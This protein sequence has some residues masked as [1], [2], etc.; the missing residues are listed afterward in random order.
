MYKGGTKV[1]LWTLISI[2]WLID[3]MVFNANFSNISAISWRY[4]YFD[5][6][7]KIKVV[8]ICPATG[9]QRPFLIEYTAS[10]L[11]ASEILIYFMSTAELFICDSIKSMIRRKGIP[12]YTHIPNLFLNWTSIVLRHIINRYNYTNISFTTGHVLYL[13]CGL[14]LQFPVSDMS[15]FFFHTKM[16]PKQFEDVTGRKQRPYIEVKKRKTKN[17]TLSKHFRNQEKS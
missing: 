16:L 7:K 5:C 12:L 3:L 13:L 9:H 8:K 17:T 10:C 2:H 15:K 4:I 14:W 1:C 6:R 11:F